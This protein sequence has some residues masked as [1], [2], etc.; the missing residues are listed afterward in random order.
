MRSA[1]ARKS[2]TIPRKRYPAVYASNYS[3]PLQTNRLSSL[4]KSQRPFELQPDNIATVSWMIPVP[5]QINLLGV[6]ILADSEKGS[7][8]EQADQYQ[9]F[10]INCFTES[11]P[12]YLLK[13]GEKQI[14]SPGT[15]RG[16]HR[17]V[18]RWR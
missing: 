1:S 7:D 8:G 13:E 17:S 10:P 5:K 4:S 9:F 3:I 18:S 11:T 15:R 12:F 14:V 6:R 16:R 2:S